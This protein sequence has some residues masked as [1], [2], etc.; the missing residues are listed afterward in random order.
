MT[1]LLNNPIFNDETAAR[2]WLEARVWPEG[3]T[4]PHCGN[5]DKAKLKALEGKSHRPG[6]YQCADRFCTQQNPAD[7]VAG[8]IVPYDRL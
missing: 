1:D 8:G 7:Q 2:E 4:C 5:A 6:L 3:P